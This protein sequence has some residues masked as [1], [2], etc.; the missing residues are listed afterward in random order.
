MVFFG[1]FGAM[2]LALGIIGGLYIVY[3]RYSL[4]LN[5]TRPLVPLV[6]MLVLG[7]AQFLSFGF[8]AFQIAS[9]RRDVHRIQGQ[10]RRNEFERGAN[11]STS[12]PSEKEM[13]RPH[14][15]AST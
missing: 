12:P 15:E 14:D 7:G 5:P 10:I 3:L 6:I 11:P 8:I 13:R 2:M 1:L 9:L 4:V